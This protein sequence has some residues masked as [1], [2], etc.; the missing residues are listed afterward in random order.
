[1]FQDKKQNFMKLRIFD[2][3]QIHTVESDT[4]VFNILSHA[5]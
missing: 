3:Q 2:V 4:Y 5:Q 1:M